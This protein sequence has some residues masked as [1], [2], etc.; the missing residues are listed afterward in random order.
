MSNTITGELRSDGSEEKRW[1]NIYISPSLHP[2]RTEDWYQ[3]VD[4]RKIWKN[5]NKWTRVIRR[6]S[7]RINYAKKS[8]MTPFDI[9]VEKYIND[10]FPIPQND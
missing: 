2:N 1:L 3:V 4:E 8:R 10:N 5:D 9:E 6:Q 7:E